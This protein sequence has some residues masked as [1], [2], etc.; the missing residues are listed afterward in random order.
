MFTTKATY[1][2]K[3]VSDSTGAI[4]MPD[5]FKS[6]AVYCGLKADPQ[7]LDLG[8]IL[9]EVPYTSGAAVFTNNHIKAAPIVYSQRL[10][11]MGMIRAIVVNSGNA[12]ACTGRQGYK[13]AKT[14]AMAA[15]RL[16]HVPQ[17]QVLVASTGIIGR[18]L[19]MGKVDS[20]IMAASKNLGDSPFYGARMARSIMTTDTFP[21]EAA[22]EVE[23]EDFCYTIGGIAKGAGMISP[24]MATMLCFITTDA[25]I[26]PHHLDSCLRRSVDQSFNQITID[27]HTSTNDMVAIMAN[28]AARR[29]LFNKS[30]I[31]SFQEALDYV[32]VQLAR[33]IVKDGEGA[34]KF[35]CIEI[36]GAKSKK[37]AEKIARAIANSPLVKTAING[38]DPNW[39]RII[40]A[41]GYAGAAIDAGRLRLSINGILIFKNGAPEMELSFN[42]SFQQR[43]H[44]EMQKS[45]I[46]FLLELGI[47]AHNATVWTCDLSHDYITI[48]ADYH[49]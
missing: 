43:L 8:I 46:S 45:E 28:G 47:G 27:G 5:G 38:G 25:P 30:H 23:T 10:I 36:I 6:G 18:R 39:G 42:K 3:E 44:S 24:D 34:S 49:T 31:Q 4:V 41:A 2:I 7:S 26:S 32:T 48:N 35:V 37:D 22:V 16:L 13:D 17:D 15:A 14:M 40:S 12:N 1:K 33:A 11:R 21:K 29:S 19:D 20:G 9:S